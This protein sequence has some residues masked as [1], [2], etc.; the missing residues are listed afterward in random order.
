MEPAELELQTDRNAPALALSGGGFRAT[1]FHCGALMRLNELGLLARVARI[2]SVSGGSITAG[3]LGVEWDRLTLQD[4]RFTNLRE[5]VIDPLREFC[6]RTIDIP[7]G[8]IGTLLPFTSVGKR[9]A[10]AYER[11]L[12]SASLQDLP[13]RPDFVFKA[14]NLQTGRLVRFQRRYMADYLIGCIMAPD[15][16][17]STVVA[18]SSAFPPILSPVKIPLDRTAWRNLPG[19]RYFGDMNYVRELRLTDGGTYDNLGL[20]S[21]DDFDP[22]I[23]SDAG[24][25]FT[26]TESASG[27]WPTQLSRVL[28]IATDQ[29]RGLRRR[30]LFERCN[31]S[32]RRFAMA[33]IEGQI[34]GRPAEQRIEF[35]P[36]MIDKLS[37]IRTRLNRFSVAEQENLI[38]W[39]WLSMDVMARS[40]LSEHVSVA[41]P[42]ELPYR[43]HR[44]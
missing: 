8:T 33:L 16:P 4:G 27:F 34:A 3:K 22:V 20:E 5:R 28:S 10:R 43:L 25:P 9:L 1:L 15:L 32:G 17:L 7:A 18:A 23:V 37:R 44:S 19:T 12:G 29:S 42:T 24:M 40:Y 41:P 11:M 36:E 6:S 14:T 38:N 31:A 30:L 35:L 13:E 26:I 39:G 2:A 21:V